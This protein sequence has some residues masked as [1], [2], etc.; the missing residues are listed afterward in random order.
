MSMDDLEK[1]TIESMMIDFATGEAAAEDAERLQSLAR[2]EPG[3]A[4]GLKRVKAFFY[5][6]QEGKEFIFDR[7]SDHGGEARCP[8]AALLIRFV[9]NPLSLE[10][11]DTERIAA[12]AAAC[13][14]CG[15]IV[16]GLKAMNDRLDAFD[17]ED[18]ARDS[19]SDFSE[20]D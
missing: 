6:V 20:D 19:F 8:D 2:K 1:N 17:P 15:E 4:E 18:A 12:H 3:I 9:E 16:R 14:V 5:A 7:E 10:P 13:A 11:A